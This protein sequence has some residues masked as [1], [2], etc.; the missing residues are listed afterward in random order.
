MLLNFREVSGLP[1]HEGRM[2]RPG[3]IFRGGAVTDPAAASRLGDHRVTTVYDLRNQREEASRPSALR[4]M[5]LRL[6]LRHHRI[7]L[8]AVGNLMRAGTADAERSRAAMLAI[9]GDFHRVF[10]PTFKA[11]L[12]DLVT[13]EGPVYIHCAVGKD[14]TGVMTAL[15][16]RALGVGR[17][18]ITREYLLSNGAREE[19]AASI[20][21][22]HPNRS[23]IDDPALRPI[24]QVE[25]AYLDAFLDSI[26][27]AD[28]YLHQ[29]IGLDGAALAALRR[30]FLE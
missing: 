6:P 3:M 27:P 18:E 4:G 2:I 21:L 29:K 1:G 15:L 24:L 17:E 25:T 26:G 12:A 30:R 5:G 23:S 20:R 13:G 28:T 10:R 11:V 16:L 22:R 8:A 9:Y 19:I 7:D 14:R